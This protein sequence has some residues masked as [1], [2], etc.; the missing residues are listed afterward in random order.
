MAPSSLEKLDEDLRVDLALF[1][2]VDESLHIHFVV[3]DGLGGTYGHTVTTEVT[4]VLVRK[5]LYALPFFGEA[6]KT[7]GSAKSTFRTCISVYGNPIHDF[8]FHF[9]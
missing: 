2:E 6:A 7:D 9:D 4:V 3:N 8:S 1:A 5:N